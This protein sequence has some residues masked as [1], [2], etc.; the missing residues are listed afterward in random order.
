VGVYDA[1][2]PSV[3]NGLNASI[4]VVFLLLAYFGTW[5]LP[6]WYKVWALKGSMQGVA[7]E[8]YREYDDEKLMKMLLKEARRHELRVTEKNFVIKRV[9]YT[10]DEINKVVNANGN[11]YFMTRRGKFVKIAFA[12]IIRADWPL[13]EGKYVDL[14]F[15][16]QV[17][18]D[19]KAVS[20]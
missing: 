17:E 5:Y 6:H 8:A 20:W 12:T 1:K 18:V 10:P 7:T 9:P 13:L 19:M 14:E 2:K 15:Q 4:L 16:R 3:F 11:T